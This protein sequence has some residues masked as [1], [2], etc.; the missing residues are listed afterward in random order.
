M[1]T[2]PEAEMPT[3]SF[4]GSQQVQEAALRAFEVLRARGMF[5]SDN[6]PIRVRKDELVAFLTGSVGVSPSDAEAALTENPEVF[7]LENNDEGVEIVITSRLGK[8][9]SSDDDGLAHT[10]A[11]R[12]MTPEPKPARP[13]A[14]VRE[15]VR[16]APSWATYTVP[17]FE[18]DE[19]EAAYAEEQK[20]MQAAETAA[21]EEAEAVRV[22]AAEKLEAA[23][24]LAAQEAE[25][26]AR[27]AAVTPDEA[28]VETVEPAFET[29]VAEVED[30]AETPVEEAPVEIEAETVAEP[31]IMEEV[32]EPQ[33][34]PVVIEEPVIEVAPVTPAAELTDV[35]GYSDEQIRTALDESIATD[36]RIAR[37]ADRWMS[38]DRVPRLSRGDIRRIKDYI[39]EQ[40]VPLTDETLVQDILGTRPNQGNYELTLFALNYRLSKERD[41]E[42]LGTNDQRFWATTNLPP[43]GTDRR[44][45]NDIGTDYRF[46]TEAVR[47]VGHRS[48]DSVDH[49]V[50]FY[51]YTLGL[52]PYDEDMQKLMPAPVESDQRNA[53]FTF[54]MPQT[55]T[56]YLVE[57]RYPTPTRGGFLLGLD[58]FYAE[59]I[60]PGAMISISATE[61]DGHY[62]IEYL[63]ADE[64]NDRLLELD[65][66][67]SPRYHFRPTTFACVV[68]DK[69]LVN[70]ERFPNLGSEKPLADK[71]RRRNDELLKA[72]FDRIGMDDGNGGKLAS[73]DDLLVAVNIERPFSEDVLRA[74]LEQ[75]SNV[76]GD[77]A[78]GYTY[79]TG[80]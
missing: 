51:E 4:S 23:R 7:A 43:I 66:R 67:R 5:M 37:F 79:V 65:D 47:D 8:V 20:R 10:F 76:S 74:V 68:D 75:D 58:D 38:E 78:N 34:A 55:Y 17:D 21:A 63:A 33:E 48:V 40:E 26:A 56:T 18:D 54:E 14:P 42:F 15:R 52:L 27:A 45:H 28:P 61:N 49:V 11:Q 72:T 50:T 12:L 70:E 35:S 24:A 80:S 69:W 31:E 62:R 46:L 3:I 13:A 59:S 53:I 2:T 32:V 73:F 44:K 19:E 41:F 36:A 30:V 77:D 71:V 22:A 6:A 16:V 57:L 29:P 9:P 64:Q 60:V 25:A 39:D 1:T